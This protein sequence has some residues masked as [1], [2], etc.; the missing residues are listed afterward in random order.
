[1]N[2]ATSSCETDGSNSEGYSYVTPPNKCLNS[3]D[4]HIGRNQTEVDSTQFMCEEK[5][6]DYKVS[7]DCI[8]IFVKQ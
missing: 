3:K 4:A 1:M 7:K 2:T 8:V 5:R 6:H